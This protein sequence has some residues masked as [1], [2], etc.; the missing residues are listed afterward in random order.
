MNKS[1]LM[2]SAFALGLSLSGAAMAQNSP[3]QGVNVNSGT[4]QSDSGDATG[5]MVGRPQYKTD[6][7][8][9]TAATEPALPNN[10]ETPGARPNTDYGTLAPGDADTTRDSVPSTTR[11][12]DSTETRAP[13]AGANSF[14]EAEAQR[15]IQGLGYSQ[16]SGLA[17][18]DQSVWRGTAI[19]NGTPV[20]VALDYRGNV[21]D[22]TK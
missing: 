18:D 13:L 12:A 11:N 14:T 15:R 5:G 9:A 1:T 17:K 21:T 19:K 16:V 4:S 10:G 2:A 6:A 3:E 7:D 8:S 22:S 20:N